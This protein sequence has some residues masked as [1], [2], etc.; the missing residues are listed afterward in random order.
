MA[1]A[2]DLPRLE[3][4]STGGSDQNP[5][6][7]LI[8]RAPPIALL[9]VILWDFSIENIRECSQPEELLEEG[10]IPKTFHRH[11]SG[12]M[13]AI[14]CNAVLASHQGRD[15]TAPETLELADFFPI[16]IHLEN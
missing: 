10:R 13:A 8:R 12:E 3:T 9:P 1:R 6:C 2:A 4:A 14:Q 7:D 5:R 16:C 11:L 15:A